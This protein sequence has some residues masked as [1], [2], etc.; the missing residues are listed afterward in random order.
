MCWLNNHV[1][2][3]Y[4]TKE[5]RQLPLKYKY[6]WN[7]LTPWG[8]VSHSYI[9]VSWSS[10]L[11]S[12]LRV[13]GSYLWCWQW[14]NRDRD[15]NWTACRFESLG[16]EADL[17]FNLLFCLPSLGRLSNLSSLLIYILREDVC[18]ISGRIGKW[19]VYCV[20]RIA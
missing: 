17:L 9:S 4:S 13:C 10:T 12:K 16:E 2:T 7:N 18:S 5:N 11:S 14:E 20:R 1:F 19:W 6:G 15:I 3:H 8:F